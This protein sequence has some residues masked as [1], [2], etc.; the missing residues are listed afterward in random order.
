MND[1]QP[2]LTTPS[3][4]DPILLLAKVL[5]DAAAAVTEL[6]G[7]ITLNDTQPQPTAP[8]D[9][10]V[11]VFLGKVL[12]DAAAAVTGLAVS[13]GDRLGLYQAMA[14]AGPLTAQEL[15]KHTGTDERYVE[16][17][18]HCQVGAGYIA[19]QPD[20]DTATY[21]LPDSHAEVLA[22]N[23]SPLTGIGVFGVLQALYRIEDRLVD[24]FR[25]GAGISWGDYPSQLYRGVARF[26]RPGYEASIVQSWLPA[27]DGVTDRLRSGGR[28]ADVGCGVGYS[29]FVMADAF[30]QATFHGL[31]SHGES[32]AA[33][34]RTARE[35]NLGNRVSFTANPASAL[36][37]DGSRY[38]LITFFDCLHDMGDPTAALRA[39]R[40]ALSDNGT[41]MLVEP[42]TAADPQANDNPVGRLFM[43][44]SPTLCLP[45]AIAQ[46]GPVALG[47][48]PGEQTLRQLCT[49][50]GFTHWRRATQTPVSAVYQLR[51]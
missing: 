17:W 26:F 43:A 12:T 8:G 14:G 50:A 11:P 34:E 7:R 13:V 41:V 44:L 10:D 40:A 36:G 51:P 31:D 48:H 16:Q 18:L 29:T 23:G 22:D 33:A 27:L 32:I 37:T 24:A 46:H 35:R 39:A 28:V 5:T 45:G 21:R 49:E 1:A 9:D 30:P 19:Y 4:D 6:A 42:N 38:D 15:A 3:D 47:N 20:G 2:H 25:T